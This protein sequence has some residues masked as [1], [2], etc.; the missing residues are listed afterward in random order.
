MAIDVEFDQALK[1]NIWQRN[2]VPIFDFF[3]CENITDRLV[4]SAQFKYL[5]KAGM[6]HWE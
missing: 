1:T 3:H 2:Y 4:E 5:F 6:A